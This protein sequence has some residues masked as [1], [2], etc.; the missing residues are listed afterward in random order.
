MRIDGDKV[1]LNK[2]YCE[3]A[4]LLSDFLIIPKNI[5]SKK[6]VLVQNFITASCLVRF[7][8]FFMSGSVDLAFL[9]F[10]L[11]QKPTHMWDFIF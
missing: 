5:E 9:P 11:I 4:M 1:K 10:D 6:N 7:A 3:N 2:I 8:A